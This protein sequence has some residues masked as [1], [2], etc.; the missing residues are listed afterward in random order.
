MASTS[1]VIILIGKPA[2]RA[3]YFTFRSFFLILIEKSYLRIY[4]IDFHNFFHH[5]DGTC[6]NVVNPVQFF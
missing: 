4:C 2:N 1:F 5:M 6:V 3:I